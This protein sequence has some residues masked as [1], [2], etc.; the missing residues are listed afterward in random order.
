MLKCPK[1]AA[2]ENQ[3]VTNRL[4]VSRRQ[5]QKASDGGN[6]FIIQELK[7]PL[8]GNIVDIENK[9]LENKQ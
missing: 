1:Q 9:I 2:K 8:K 3:H 6:K 5:K 4:H 7:G